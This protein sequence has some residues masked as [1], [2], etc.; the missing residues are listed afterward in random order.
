MTRYWAGPW[1]WSS[2]GPTPHY[3]APS[4]ASALVDLRNIETQS[5]GNHAAGVGNGFFC[6][7]DDVDLG[8]DYALLGQGYITEVQT[9]ASVRSAW[10]SMF[11]VVP[12]G[13]TLVDY[14]AYTL[15]D[16]SD[17]TGSSGPKPI[18]PC[19]QPIGEVEIILAG[20]SVVWRRKMS[21]QNGQSKH[22]KAVRDLL[23]R[24]LEDIA[25]ND[26]DP[27]LWR[28]YL[29]SIKKKFGQRWNDE[30]EDWVVSAKLK[31]KGKGKNSRTFADEPRTSY[32]ETWPSNGST[33][34]SGQDRG[35]AYQTGSGLTV[36]STQL[37]ITNTTW[38]RAYMTSAMSSADHYAEHT[39]ISGINTS[40]AHAVCARASSSAD[41][42]YFADLYKITVDAIRLYKVVAATYTQLVLDA[43]YTTVANDVLKVEANGSSIKNYVNGGTAKQSATDTSITGILYAGVGGVTT[44]ATGVCDSWT[45]SDL[46]A[47]ASRTD[48]GL[49]L[50]V[51]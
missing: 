42:C 41:T 46:A 47:G 8:S 15:T 32:T 51:S 29:G 7:P 10:Q 13:D 6:T 33:I 4:G 3:R 48:L 19:V 23:R 20:H 11:G 9:N 24:E 17:P 43:S 37:N 21:V 50:G 45:C 31:A 30:S 38:A 35:W 26:P 39:I 34:T 25:E 40:I 14:L 36:A 18:V 44:G 28:K 2:A 12:Q 27:T 1:Q 5:A 22:A 49:L 16:G